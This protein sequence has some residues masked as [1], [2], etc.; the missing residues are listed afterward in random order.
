MT[1]MKTAKTFE[2]EFGDFTKF[3]RYILGVPHLYAN[4]GIE[5]ARK[6]NRLIGSTFTCPY[7][8]IGDRT[9]PHSV[10]PRVYLLAQNESPLLKCIAIVVQTDASRQVALLEKQAADA[11]KFP[12]E[13]FDAVEDAKAWV[14]SILDKIEKTNS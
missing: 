13:V 8:Y 2:L 14:E 9:N 12:F 1:V 4:I 11:A 3:D 5:E 7:G 10:D 6:I